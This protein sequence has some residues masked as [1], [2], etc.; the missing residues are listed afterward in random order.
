MKLKQLRR[1]WNHLA[2]EDFFW[3]VLTKHEKRGGNWDHAE[4]FATG[5]SDVAADLYRVRSLVPSMRWGRA[6]DFGCGVGRL[7]QALALH[8]ESVAGVDIAEEMLAVA[9]TY[10]QFPSRVQYFHNDRPNLG[11]FSDDSFDFIY[12]RITL[13]HMEPRYMKLYIREFVRIL[14][15]GGVALFQ[16]PAVLKLGAWEQF[17]FSWWPPTLY[18]RIKRYSRYSFDRWFPPLGTMQMY[19]LDPEEVKTCLADSGAVLLSVHPKTEPDSESYF[20][21][22]QK[23]NTQDQQRD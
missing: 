4:F 16:V 8:F 17:K 10:N 19:I 11:L 21:L 7:T 13:Q 1:H 18:A 14:A 9:E 15:K 5:I 2:K 22:A 12:S 6:L 20:Y 23:A 3:A